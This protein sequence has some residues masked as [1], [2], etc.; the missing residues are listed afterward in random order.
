MSG[1]LCFS[2]A[3]APNPEYAANIYLD[4]YV[5]DLENIV[6]DVYKNNSL[7]ECTSGDVCAGPCPPGLYCFK[8]GFSD[9]SDIQLGL[10][11]KMFYL[12]KFIVAQAY[13]NSSE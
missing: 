13:L 7:S 4:V 11:T 1:F 12:K 2:G 5:D 3:D 6:F 10:I 9:L 8:N